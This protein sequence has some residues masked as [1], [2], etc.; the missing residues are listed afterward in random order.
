MKTNKRT[1]LFANILGG[2]GYAS[3]LLQWLWVSVLFLPSFFENASVKNFLLPEPTGQPTL[4][5]ELAGPPIIL[6][7][8]AVI[9]TLIIL[10]LTV[11]VVARLPVTIAKTG[12]NVTKKAAIASL[13]LVTRHRKLPAKKQRELTVRMIKIIKLFMILMPVCLLGFLVITT[14]TI[15]SDVAVFVESVLALG[16]IVWFSSEHFVS[17]RSNKN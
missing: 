8:I 13:P 9:L 5:I 2:F 16:S 6:T 17:G 7:S 1:Q 15:D 4:H 14:L 3:V 10:V 11:V 12:K